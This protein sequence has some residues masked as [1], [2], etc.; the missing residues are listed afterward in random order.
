M[1]VR[2]TGLGSG[3]TAADFFCSSSWLTREG[4]GITLAAKGAGL[5]G[6]TL[7]VEEGFGDA[8]G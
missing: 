6:C 5:G 1:D 8:A 4:A 3:A 2:L 7:A